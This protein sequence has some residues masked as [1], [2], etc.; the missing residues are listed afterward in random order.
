VL[1]DESPVAVDVMRRRLG[2][3]PQRPPLRIAGV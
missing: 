2:E 1:I 3:D